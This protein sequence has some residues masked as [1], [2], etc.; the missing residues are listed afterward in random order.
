MSVKV[1]RVAP[2]LYDAVLTYAYAVNKAI[3]EGV[4]TRDG[5]KIAANFANSIFFGTSAT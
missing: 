2:Y 3:M 1:N 4:D 5:T